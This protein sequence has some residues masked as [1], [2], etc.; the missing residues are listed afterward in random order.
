MAID[1]L[2]ESSLSKLQKKGN[3]LCVGFLEL[4]VSLRKVEHTTN[5]VQTNSKLLLVFYINPKGFALVE[6]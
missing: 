2:T 6:G 1:L 4:D 5:A 3:K